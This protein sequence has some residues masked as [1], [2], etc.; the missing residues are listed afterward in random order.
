M[1]S[2][3]S[4]VRRFD[5]QGWNSSCFD[6]SA[7]GHR[8]KRE[9]TSCRRPAGKSPPRL[10]G[11]CGQQFVY[12]VSSMRYCS[13]ECKLDDPAGWIRLNHGSLFKYVNM[14]VPG[15][16]GAWRPKRVSFLQHRWVMARKLG[17]LL[18]EHET[19]H[20]INGIADDNRI[21]NLQLR[22]GNHGQGARRICG[23]CGSEDVRDIAL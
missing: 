7:C 19:V 4:G 11:S 1:R 5:N 3:I 22:S 13:W 20:H 2:L 16:E 14:L 8:H 18:S 21:E 15:S 9:I 10:C 17:R 12:R 23:S 6:H